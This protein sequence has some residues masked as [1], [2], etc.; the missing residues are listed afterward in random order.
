MSKNIVTKDVIPYEIVNKYNLTIVE[1]YDQF[2]GVDFNGKRTGTF[3]VVLYPSKNLGCFGDGV[4]ITTNYDKFDRDFKIFRNYGSEKRY[5]NEIVGCS[6]KLLRVK[7]S[8]LDEFAAQRE[9]IVNRYKFILGGNHEVNTF[10]TYPFKVIVLGEKNEAWTKGKILVKDDVWIGMDSMILSGVTIGQGA[11]IAAG[12][13]VTEDVPPYVI[14]GGNPAK[15]IK[16]RFSEDLVE[17]MIM[18]N[19][20][21]IDISKIKN[22]EKELY[23]KLNTFNIEVIRKQL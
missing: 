9:H 2:N 22:V 7:L 23:E 3:G 8:H 10:T 1:N 11:I 18:F 20:S 19:W 17:E 15:L 12:S 21:K 4:F 5:H 13:V 16:Y 14:V 6:S